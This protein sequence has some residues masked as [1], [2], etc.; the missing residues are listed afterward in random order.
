MVL[1][2]LSAWL[3]SQLEGAVCRRHGEAQIPQHR[4]GRRLTQGLVV[5][6]LGQPEQRRH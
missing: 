6:V 5:A 4:E 3:Y 2:L 1:L